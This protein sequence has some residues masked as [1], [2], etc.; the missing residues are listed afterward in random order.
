MWSWLKTENEDEKTSLLEAEN[1]RNKIAE[2]LGNPS[3]LEKVEAIAISRTAGIWRIK[4]AKII[5]GTFEGKRVERLVLDV[6]VPPE[7]VLKC[8]SSFAEHGLKYLDHPT[9]KPTSREIKAENMLDFLEK[10]PSQR[11]TY[12]KVTALKY[13]GHEF[14][15][16]KIQKIR[17]LILT[18]ANWNRNQIAREV[19]RLFDFRQS[20]HKLKI[21]QINQVLKRM[22]MDNLISLPKLTNC[23]KLKTNVTK[24]PIKKRVLEKS[25]KKIT[26]N[27]SSIRRIQ[28][29][30]VLCQK[31]LA[32]WRELIEEYHYIGVP[33]LFGAQMKYLV[34]GGKDVEPTVGL[35][36]DLSRRSSNGITQNIY[37]TIN[38][39]D[40]LLAAVGFSSSAWKLQSRD[41]FIGWNDAE[42]SANL[43]LVANNARF[44][45][46]PWIKFPNLASRILGCV[47]K[48]LPFD[49]EAK[50]HYKPVLL[51]TFVQIDR[52]R[53]TCYRAAN[54]IHVGRTKGYSLYNKYKKKS[55]AKNVYVY[56][57]CKDFRRKLC[58]EDAP[59]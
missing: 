50:Y 52:F 17:T 36:K 4:R 58:G 6:R 18:N 32:L 21:S 59:L 55:P 14:N 24:I 20:D 5:L 45:I 2:I 25:F 10:A 11:S 7:S 48:Q 35:L 51:E 29:I 30:P 19:C 57:L 27:H 12:C 1:I 15:A 34:Y 26:L 37:A 46:L 41:R 31:D 47:A 8:Q 28:L 3:Q 23:N 39:G 49:W 54:W 22:A 38:R 33:N 40:Q 13:I 53:G 43:K 42:R 44:L 56:P 16:E 9:R